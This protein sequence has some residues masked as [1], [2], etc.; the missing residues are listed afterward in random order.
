MAF[1]KRRLDWD[2][3]AV[4]ASSS[5]IGAGGGSGGG[6]ED[7]NKSK[8][9]SKSK[10]TTADVS[11][12]PTVNPLN[13]VPYSKKYHEILAIRKKLPVW[14]F[15][16]KLEKDIAENQVVIVEGETGSGK[17]TQVSEEIEEKK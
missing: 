10:S 15:L 16:D 8:T 17:T 14:Q 7:H 4:S 2:S 13:G 1:S 11:A 9:E 6:S 5:S 3:N 12:P